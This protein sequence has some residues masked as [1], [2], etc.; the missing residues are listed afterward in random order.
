MYGCSCILCCWFISGATWLDRLPTWLELNRA[1]PALQVHPT[2]RRI[3]AVS[4]KVSNTSTCIY[5]AIKL[6]FK[7]VVHSYHWI[8]ITSLLLY[9]S[10]PSCI[11]SDHHHGL[12]D[13]HH[14]NSFHGSDYLVRHHNC[15]SLYNGRHGCIVCHPQASYV[16]LSSW[17]LKKTSVV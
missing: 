12:S 1:L 4:V 8:N 10:F 15:W 7:I 3:C 11:G 2:A 6:P 17:T 14:G 9:D 5:C 16:N 13:H